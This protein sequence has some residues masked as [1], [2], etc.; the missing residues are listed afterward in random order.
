[1]NTT[2]AR[3]TTFVRE[4]CQSRHL[5]FR[6]WPSAVPKRKATP[7]ATSTQ[8]PSHMHGRRA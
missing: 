3:P 7:M 2:R 5:P 6:Q 8:Y 1:M 4:I